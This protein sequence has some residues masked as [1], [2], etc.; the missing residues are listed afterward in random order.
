[1]NRIIISIVSLVAIA[2]FFSFV[3]FEKSNSPKAE[4]VKWVS[5]EEAEK[6]AKKKPKK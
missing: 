3:T 6:L 5:L 4:E 2:T 1:M